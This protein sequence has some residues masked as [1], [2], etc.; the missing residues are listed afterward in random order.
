MLATSVAN[1]AT[2]FRDYLGADFSDQIQL[3]EQRLGQ[4]LQTT[5]SRSDESTFTL[6][7]QQLPPAA[8]AL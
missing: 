1:A 6:E 4:L 2:A 5:A 3:V 7:S 8:D